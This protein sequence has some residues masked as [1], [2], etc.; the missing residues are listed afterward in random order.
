MSLPQVLVAEP[1]H[2]PIRLEGEEVSQQHRQQ[3]PWATAV[4]EVWPHPNPRRSYTA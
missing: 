2:S 1:L 3:E 4:P